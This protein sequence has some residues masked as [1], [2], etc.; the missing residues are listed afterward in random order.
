MALVEYARIKGERDDRIAAA[1]SAG[2][3]V[4]EVATL[5]GL[6]RQHVHAILKGR[7]DAEA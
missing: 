1:V 4:T 5:V 3:P 2:V 7:R 6:N